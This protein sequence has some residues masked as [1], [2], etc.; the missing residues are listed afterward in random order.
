MVFV[1]CT[2]GSDAMAAE[3]VRGMFEVFF[4]AAQ[5]GDDFADLRM[6]LRSSGGR[7]TGFRASSGGDG[8]ERRM[9]ERRH[10]S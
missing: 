8:L 6:L 3:V 10:Q 5:R 4:S 2:E 7:L 1:R 9:A